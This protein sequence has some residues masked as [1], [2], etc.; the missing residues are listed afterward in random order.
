M[1]PII[2]LSHLSISVTDRDTSVQ[3]YGDVLG[4]TPF[5]KED[6]D[7]FLKTICIHSDGLTVLGIVQHHDAAGPFDHRR[8]GLDHLAFG[9]ADRAALDDWHTRLTDLGVTCSPIAETGFGPVLCF[10]DPDDI[11]LE[12]FALNPPG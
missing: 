2:G 7:R 11:Q 1:A 10:R 12:L 3:W 8:A 4:F 5:Q 6:D 9:V